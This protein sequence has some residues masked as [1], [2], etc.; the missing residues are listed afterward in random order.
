MS[1]SRPETLLVLILLIAISTVVGALLPWKEI[2]ERLK[3]RI[4]FVLNSTHVK[5]MTEMEA[6][7]KQAARSAIAKSALAKDTEISKWRREASDW[8]AEAQQWQKKYYN[9]L[10]KTPNS[11]SAQF[12][13]EEIRVLLQLVHPDKHGGK[14][15]AVEITKKLNQLRQ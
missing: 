13:K 14:A 12:T 9:A 10:S 2:F 5:R 1:I 11:S 3:K 6:F 4:P 7:F 8:E 15:S